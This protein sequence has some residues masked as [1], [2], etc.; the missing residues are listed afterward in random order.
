MSYTRGLPLLVLVA[1]AIK[2]DSRGPIFYRQERMGRD[3]RSFHILK[4][5]SMTVDAE[6]A[7]APV[8]AAVH[9]SR[10]TRVGSFIRLTR[11]DEIPQAI[12]ILRGEMAFVG[13]RPEQPH[14]VEELAA[15]IPHY[16]LRHTVRP[17]LTG[18]AQV[19]Y[20]YGASEEDAREKLEYDLYY[21]RHQ[22]YVIDA[23]ILARLAT[24][25]KAQGAQLV[26]TE[27]DAV[28]LPPAFRPNVLVLPVRLELDDWSVVDAALAGLFA[29]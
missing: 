14:Y 29:R 22:G 15:K 12:N 21:L 25:A 5:R 24:E 16:E 11:I 4:F 6:K 20:P 8:W 10:V 23:R 19:K 27:K 7:G 18:W 2:L 17:G 1:V 26:T 9:D 3:H 28:R 13:P